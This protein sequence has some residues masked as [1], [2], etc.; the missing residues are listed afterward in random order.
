MCAL[1]DDIFRLCTFVSMSTHG[2]IRR[3][4]KAG[5][6]LD[7]GSSEVIMQEKQGRPGLGSRDLAL[8]LEHV[9]VIH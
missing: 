6:P 7:T 3:M 4:L 1:R 2:E 5:R 8:L 9:P